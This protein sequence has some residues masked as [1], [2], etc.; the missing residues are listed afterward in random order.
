MDLKRT[1]LISKASLL[2]IVFAAW[3]G[4]YPLIALRGSGYLPAYLLIFNLLVIASFMILSIR[5]VL[6]YASVIFPVLLFVISRFYITIRKEYALSAA[7]D[8]LFFLLNALT[9]YGLVLYYYYKIMDE[10][11][12]DAVL[13]ENFKE[14][15]TVLTV[16]FQENEEKCKSLKVELERMRK[17]SHTAY[18]L[19]S[20]MDEIKVAESLIRETSNILSVSRVLFSR[21][22]KNESRFHVFAQMGYQVSSLNQ[23]TDNLDDWIS[24]SRLPTLVSNINT[25]TKIRIKRYSSFS[26]YISIIAAPVIVTDRV[27]GIL[28]AESKSTDSF[29]N[30]DLRVL[31]Y[32]SDLAS[33]AFETLFYFKEV[34]RL[35]IT[36]GITGL[37]VHKHMLEKFE[38]EIARFYQN[39]VPVSFI[40][41]DIDNFKHF[42]DTYG[43][44]F[45]DAILVA[46]SKVIQ[47]T[48]REVDFPVRYGGDEFAIILPQ[49]DTTGAV[50]TA[51]RLF[52]R[53]K[54]IDLN[55]LM[56]GVKV[57]EK[58][59]ISLGV[60]TFKKSYRNYTNFIDKV[61]SQLYKAKKE[62]KNK[63]GIIE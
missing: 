60:G 18:V 13:I 55:L 53:I 17:L 5:Y 25:E 57:N 42:N 38:N 54:A 1:E 16:N 45:G 43:H 51:E 31:D 48:I 30:D 58:M 27:Y 6:L 52:Q 37:F 14:E 29:T 4:F 20:T 49:T 22:S 47:I 36:D 41:M 59:T 39:K 56:P 40:M 15:N 33:I 63:I 61:D 62:G 46:V 9:Y 21:Y 10:H 11:K 3:T 8:S 35:A 26:N 19:G 12:S 44:L 7:N 34:E 50:S 32:I 23:P 2:L 24:E 28:R